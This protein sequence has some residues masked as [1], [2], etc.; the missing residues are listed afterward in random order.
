MSDMAHP[1]TK[2]AAAYDQMMENVD[3]D[4]WADYID[5]LFSFYN[6]HP[7]RVLDIACGTGSATIKL[8]EKGYQMS[9]TDRA[10]E[11]LIW[12]REKAEKNKLH[13]TLWQQDMRY[14]SIKKPYYDA[15]L[16]LYDSINYITTEEE[17]L[18][19]FHRVNEALRPKGMFIFDVTTEHNIVKHFHRQT[20]AE[21]YDDFS[22]IWRNL[23]FHQEKVCKT[24][25]TFFLKEDD[26]YGKY[27]ELHI[28]KIYSIKQMKK[29]LDD[30]GFKLL[31]SFDAFTFNRWGRT[32][33]RINLTAV[34]ND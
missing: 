2:F 20:F 28:Q 16:C 21:S 34:K 10:L 32:S 13:L 18:E 19:F 6:H 33:E 12:A 1:Y 4:R 9:G 17:M 29:M 8:A 30:S 3:Y 15:A 23:Y 25:L 5:R 26:H 11:M 22:Y 27:E 24:I 31:S 7:K 14:L